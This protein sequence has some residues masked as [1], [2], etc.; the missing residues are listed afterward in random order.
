MS[1]Q[2][3][4]I[5]GGAGFIGS[6]LVERIAATS[7]SVFVLDNL[8]EQVHGPDPHVEFPKNVSLH[9]SS[10]NDSAS[11]RELIQRIRPDLVVHLA[12]ETGTGQSM[13]E[14]SRYTDVNVTGTAILLECLLHAGA[15]P[16][17]VLASSRAIYGEGPY[18]TDRGDIVVPGSRDPGAMAAGRYQPTSGDGILEPVAADEDTRPNPVSVY[19]STK[20]MQEHLFNQISLAHDWPCRILRFQNVYGDGQSLRNPYTGVLSVFCNQLLS[21]QDISVFED[22]RIVRDFVYVDD[23]V[24]AL[25]SATRYEGE[26]SITANIGS[27]RAVTILE[28]AETL[29]A[30]TDA[31]AGRVHVTG[32][33]RA[34]D[35]RHA[36]ADI[37]NAR[38]LLK[39]RP[40]VSLEQGLTRLVDWSRSELI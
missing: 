11:T 40:Q 29:A 18:R 15:R 38:R 7:K 9:R 5:T 37:E 26:R 1:H 36:V 12:A 6:R 2:S 23:V 35:I 24:D 34:G 16:T 10:I 21:G 8:L 19:A 3:V 31:G 20:L 30:L 39:W 13:E 22:G 4:L 17:L 33:F 32:Q 28:V 25:V 14:I 27:G